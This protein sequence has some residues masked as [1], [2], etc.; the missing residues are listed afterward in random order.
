VYGLAGLLL[1]YIDSSSVSHSVRG[2]V[3][4]TSV[5]VLRFLCEHLE[6]LPLSVINR[7]LMTHDVLLS[8][9]PL[10]ENPPWTRRRADGK[11]EKLID[12]KW[13]V[14]PNEDLLRITRNEGQVRLNV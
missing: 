10:I 14:V 6:S 3:A 12:F 8:L 2:Q 5:A 11:W 13:T 1:M 7:M 9:I 4:V